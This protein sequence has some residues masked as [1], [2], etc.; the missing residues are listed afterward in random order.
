MLIKM[1]DNTNTFEHSMVRSI[2]IIE[3]VYSSDY[4]VQVNLKEDIFIQNSFDKKKDA[5][6]ELNRLTEEVNDCYIAMNTKINP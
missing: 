6:N 5:I 3:D 2:V 1:S 4:I